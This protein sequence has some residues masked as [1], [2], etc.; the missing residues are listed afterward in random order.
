M[1]GSRLGALRLSGRDDVQVPPWLAQAAALAWRI[2]V[3]VAAGSLL[4]IAVVRLRVLFI[5]AFVAL[6]ATTVLAP[7]VNRLKAKRWPPALATSAAMGGAIAIA[8][9]IVAVLAPQVADELDDVGQTVQAGTERLLTWLSRGPLDLEQQ[10]INDFLD[11]ARERLSANAGRI[12]GGA[13]AGT[14]LVAEII[15]GIL[16]TLVMTFFFVKDGGMMARWLLDVVTPTQ[17][18]L[19]RRMAGR[20]W[21]TLTG[22]VRGIAVIAFADA[23]IIGIGL[24]IIGV[25]LVIPLMV[26]TFIGGFFPLIGAVLAGA[27]AA[28]VALV[29]TGFLDA[30]LVVAVVT[31][32]QQ[33]EG[34]VLQPLLMGRAVKLHPLVVLLGVT[35]G[36]FLGGIAGAFVAVPLIAVIVSAV[37]VARAGE[38]GGREP[39]ERRPEEEGRRRRR[40]AALP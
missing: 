37:G 21:E 16:L 33:V 19:V 8:A 26:L 1:A 40:K 9:G 7:L 32:V 17:R 29:T 6:L 15:A 22:Y 10:Q 18:D 36:A 35:G 31:V 13:L 25:P 4:V 14:V 3:V 39:D 34:D 5:P 23:V 38:P 24:V 11:R 30:L 2:L 20:A 12:A 27:V 28:L